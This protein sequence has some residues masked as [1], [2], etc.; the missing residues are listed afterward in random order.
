MKSCCLDI[1]KPITLQLQDVFM[2][3]TPPNILKDL[4]CINLLQN[5][6]KSHHMQFNYQEDN[7]EK[8]VGELQ[9]A[10]QNQSFWT[11]TFLH[12]GFKAM[13]KSKKNVS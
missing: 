5:S 1:L 10:T 7:T 6:Q 4:S 3:L 11:I 12:G 13:S 9:A 2:Q 8:M